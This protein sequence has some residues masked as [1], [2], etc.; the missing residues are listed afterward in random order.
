MSNT[1]PPLVYPLPLTPSPSRGG[2]GMPDW[3]ADP[4]DELEAAEG[5]APRRSPG[6]APQ[7]C[8]DL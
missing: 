2:G 6:R 5:R 8:L 7:C 3:C 4:R 1:V